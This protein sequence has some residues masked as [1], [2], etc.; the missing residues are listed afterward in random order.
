MLSFVETT[1][2]VAETVVFRQYVSV[3]SRVPVRFTERGLQGST[4]LRIPEVLPTFRMFALL[5][6]WILLVLEALYGEV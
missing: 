4:M 5:L 1:H 3:K 2:D 6:L